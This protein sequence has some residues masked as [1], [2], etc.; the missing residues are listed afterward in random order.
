[1]TTLTE[2]IIS[3]AVVGVGV[4]VVVTRKHRFMVLGVA[5]RTGS[6]T[7]TIGRMMNRTK[8]HHQRRRFV[9]SII[10]FVVLVV[11]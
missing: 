3:T 7:R 4:G 2:K 11:G 9:V 1:M 10:I 6:G 5:V 8:G